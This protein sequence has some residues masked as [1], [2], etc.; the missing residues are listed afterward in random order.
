MQS[1]CSGFL[2][3]ITLFVTFPAWGQ[4]IQ[5]APVQNAPAQNAPVQPAPQSAPQS[6]HKSGGDFSD[7]TNP[8]PKNVVPK[9]TII[10]KGAWSSASDSTTPLP[11]GSAVTNNV[12]TNRYFGITYALPPDWIQKFTPPPPSET[13]GYV[14]AQIN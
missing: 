14:L 9:D 8:D 5:S 4:M 3:L 6:G 10:V 12:F 2:L 1:R 7:V 11:G 13:G